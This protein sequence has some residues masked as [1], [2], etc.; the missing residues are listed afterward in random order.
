MI[1]DIYIFFLKYAYLTSFL[2]LQNGLRFFRRSGQHGPFF[3]QVEMNTSESISDL[4]NC[5][6]M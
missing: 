2:C 5:L 4:I 6:H 3:L 1:E